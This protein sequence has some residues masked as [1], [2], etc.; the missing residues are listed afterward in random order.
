MRRRD[1]DR[2][3]GY[4]FRHVLRDGLFDSDELERREVELEEVP[5]AD[6]P[7]EEP[8]EPWAWQGKDMPAPV[9][10]RLRNYREFL[11]QWRRDHPDEPDEDA[12]EGDGEEVR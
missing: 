10:D 9:R 1:R 5:P 6:E 2:P 7:A 11:Q 8:S 4:P 3:E 12:P